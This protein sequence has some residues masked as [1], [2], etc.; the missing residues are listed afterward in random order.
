MVRIVPS[1]EYE[2]QV[3]HLDPLSK[4]RIE[5]QIRKIVGDPTVG[6]PLKYRRNERSLYVKPFRL[7]YCLKDDQIILLK[8]EHRKAAYKQ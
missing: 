5:K 2:K 6:K 8:F 3:K 4:D 1:K 7:I